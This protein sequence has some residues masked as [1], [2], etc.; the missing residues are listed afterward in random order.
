MKHILDLTD[1][2]GNR[3]FS[4]FYNEQQHYLYC[5]WEGLTV[6]SDVYAGSEEE[7]KWAAANA[8]TSNCQAVIN[9]CCLIK[10]SLVDTTDWATKVWSPAMYHSGILYNAIIQSE[11]VFSQLSLADFEE[12][13]AGS[14]HIINKIFNSL[15]AGEEWIAGKMADN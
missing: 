9:D 11:D 8:R 3:F 13:S 12:L 15:E 5:K 2:L 7:M 10:G 6:S 14:G 1:N 4:L